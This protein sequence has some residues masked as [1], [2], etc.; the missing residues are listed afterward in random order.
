MQGISFFKDPTNFLTCP[1]FTLAAAL[2]FEADDSSAAADDVRQSGHKRDVPGA[3]AYINR[4]LAVKKAVKKEAKRNQVQLTP[5]LTSHSFRRGSAMH[6]NDGSLA[7]NWIIERGGWQ[8]D[9]VS[10]AF[11][12]MLG[13]TQADQKMS[14]VLS[15]WKPK[16]WCTASVF[17]RPRATCPDG[18][19]SD[20]HPDVL[21]RCD[22]SELVTKMWKAMTA[23]AIGEAEVLAWSATIRRAFN[24]PVEPSSRRDSNT[25]SS[26]LLDLLKLQSKQLDVLILLNKRLEDRLLA[27]EMQ[28]HTQLG[29]PTPSE[30]S[31]ADQPA[32]RTASQNENEAH[33][34]KKKGPQS[35]SAVWYQW[36]TAEP[37]V[38]ASHCEENKTVRV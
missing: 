25:E 23:R 34:P 22:A 27:V 20:D 24:S 26:A 38:Y 37:R 5:G 16:T 33:R 35:L 1:L 14:R 18:H 36:F 2:L 31:G 3:H 17:E 30:Q 9:K 13:T 6:A 29:E 28:M 4:L 15:G 8:L 7:E 12:Y 11:G 10:N 21:L 19:A 32:G